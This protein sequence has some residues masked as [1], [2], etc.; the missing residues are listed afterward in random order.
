M[1]YLCRRL[2]LQ[3]QVP[4]YGEGSHTQ[5]SRQYDTCYLNTA[6][7]LGKC[8]S[9]LTHSQHSSE[10]DMICC[11]A[12]P[13][14][15][16]TCLPVGLVLLASLGAPAHLGHSPSQEDAGRDRPGSAPLGPPQVR[17]RRDV[18]QPPEVLRDELAGSTCAHIPDEGSRCVSWNTRG[19]LGSP[20]SN[21]NMLI[22]HALPESM[23]SFAF[24]KHTGRMNSCRLFKS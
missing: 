8:R 18:L 12:S 6:I 20:A 4:R 22:S 5:Y 1:V 2:S 9:I 13:F 16:S 7:W 11:R 15:P 17:G 3:D 23:T 19:L 21:G 24:R 14:C 10:L